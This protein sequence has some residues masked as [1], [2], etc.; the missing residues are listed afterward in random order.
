MPNF[1]HMKPKYYTVM[2]N[3]YDDRFTENS[4]I[5]WLRMIQPGKSLLKKRHWVYNTCLEFPSLK[6][7]YLYL[8]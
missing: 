8:Q 6:K 3:Y 4:D 2:F 1:P 7:N 5:K